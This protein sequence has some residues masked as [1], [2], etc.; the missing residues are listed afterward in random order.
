MCTNIEFLTR[1]KEPLYASADTA[2]FRKKIAV[3]IYQARLI[4]APELRK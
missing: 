3:E 1:G 2:Y 4:E